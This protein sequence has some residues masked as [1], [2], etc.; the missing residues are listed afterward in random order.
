MDN[1]IGSRKGRPE[2]LWVYSSALTAYNSMFD[3]RQ[4]LAT[5]DDEAA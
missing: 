3:A 5:F 1:S 2:K 4:L